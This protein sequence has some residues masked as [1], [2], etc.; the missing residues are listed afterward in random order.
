MSFFE[1]V[2]VQ[3]S[4]MCF[5]QGEVPNFLG[6]ST[7]K[8][9]IMETKDKVIL[10]V[11]DRL[12]S[13]LS[14]VAIGLDIWSDQSQQA[15]MAVKAF[16]IDTR[17]PGQWINE[18]ALL[19]FV[20]FEGEHTGIRIAAIVQQLLAQYGLE[21]RAMAYTM[22]NASNNHAA[23]DAL[24]DAYELDYDGVTPRRPF[25]VPCLAHVIQLA[26][27][28][29]LS[30]AKCTPQKTNLL[31]LWQEDEGQRALRE[32]RPSGQIS[33]DDAD[34]ITHT[35]EKVRIMHDTTRINTN[36]TTKFYRF[37]LL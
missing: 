36:T 13:D 16:W 30:L 11:Q 6:A 14:P 21:D 2:E 10:E 31:Q 34:W 32:L 5:T 35:F 27:G 33:P 23:F 8:R 22:D 26:S 29:I 1:E 25:K 19:G 20:P 9:A 18:E 3:R 17:T 37:V 4:F 7:V 12:P 24:R 28:R 15:F